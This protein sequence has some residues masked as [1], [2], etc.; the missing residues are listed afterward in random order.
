MKRNLLLLTTV[1]T[2]ASLAA[3]AGTI[4]GKVSGVS[5]NLQSA[6]ER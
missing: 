6:E 3:H 5:G 2:L 4:S 1:L